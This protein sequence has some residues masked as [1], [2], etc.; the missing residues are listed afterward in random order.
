MPSQLSLTKGCSTS[1]TPNG[2]NAVIMSMAW[3]VVQ[4]ALASI[5]MALVCL[6]NSF[7]ISISSAVPSFIL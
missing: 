4:A 1:S 2:C 5:N 6:R 7:I 3:V